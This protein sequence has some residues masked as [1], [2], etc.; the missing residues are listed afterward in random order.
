MITE[1]IITASVL[2]LVGLAILGVAVRGAPTAYEDQFGFHEGID[3][4]RAM[5]FGAELQVAAVV[6]SARVPK[7]GMR[8]RRVLQRAAKTS[9]S[10]SQSNVAPS[11]L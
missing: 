5:D 8:A 10:V 6:R 11:A 9:E 2:A 3:P 4:Q 1:M 7:S